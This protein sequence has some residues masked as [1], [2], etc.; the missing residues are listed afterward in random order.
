MPKIH[1]LAIPSVLAIMVIASTGS[2]ITADELMVGEYN[3]PATVKGPNQTEVSGKVRLV[4]KSIDKE[5]NVN[6]EVQG[7]NGLSGKL[8]LH[9]TYDRQ[10]GK[11]RLD[12]TAVMP[13]GPPPPYLVKY[14]SKLRATVKGNRIT[15]NY[16]TIAN[17]YVPG[18][19]G[20]EFD[21]EQDGVFRADYDDEYRGPPPEDEE[22][23]E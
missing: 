15:G 13:G 11:L 19:K 10:R 8:I 18:V 22:S 5:G 16:N 9:G 20:M 7:S 21:Y 12:G 23:P 1:E 2:T 6:A 4:V 17:Y 3:G 14:K